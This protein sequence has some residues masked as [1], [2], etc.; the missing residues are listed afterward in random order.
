LSAVTASQPRRDRQGGETGGRTEPA[1][2]RGVNLKLG[3]IPGHSHKLTLWM[4]AGNP[5]KLRV[6]VRASEP[7]GWQ[8]RIVDILRRQQPD[9]P[10][11]AFENIKPPVYTMTP[12]LGAEWKEYTLDCPFDGMPIEGYT[13]SIAPTGGAATYWLDTISFT[14]QWK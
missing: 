7:A 8:M 6:S 2:D 9:S 3:H 11:I 12:Q 14:P 13:L 10:D 1:R 4:R 5:A